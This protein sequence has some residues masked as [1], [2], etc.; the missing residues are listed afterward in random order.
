MSKVKE[1]PQDWLDWAEER[2]ERAQEKYA[3]GS[4]SAARTMDSYAT[5]ISLIEYGISARARMGEEQ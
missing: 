5:L 3:Y 1:T 4:A 2:Y